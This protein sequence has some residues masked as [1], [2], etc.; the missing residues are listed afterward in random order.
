MLDFQCAGPHQ[1][2]DQDHTKLT[3]LSRQTALRE[4]SVTPESE[5]PAN[6]EA[7]LGMDFHRI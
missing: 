7:K 4:Q 2:S 6:S 1:S 5:L 3:T